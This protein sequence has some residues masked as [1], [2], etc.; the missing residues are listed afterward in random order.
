MDEIIVKVWLKKTGNQ[1]LVTIP[2]NSDINPG[3]YIQIIKVNTKTPKCL[4]SN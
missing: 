3:D 2:A 4:N 1:K